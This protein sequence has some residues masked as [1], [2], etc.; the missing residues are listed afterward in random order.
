MGELVGRAVAVR[1]RAAAV[2][3]HAL[4]PDRVL[5]PMSM[6]MLV[7]VLV[8]L[9]LLLTAWTTPGTLADVVVNTV[10]A[11][12]FPGMG[13]LLVARRPSHPIGWLYCAA[14]LLAV[15]GESGMR[16]ATYTLVTA[17]DAALPG[18]PAAAWLG[19]E[20]EKVGLGLLPFLLLLFPDG[21]LP[22]R[23]WRPLAWLICL[24][25][26]L[27]V[28]AAAVVSGPLRDADGGA[29]PAVNPLAIEPVGTVVEPLVGLGGGLIF[30]AG[31]AAAGSLLLRFRTQRGDERQ[32][33]KWV[34]YAAV[35]MLGLIG[36]NTLLGYNRVALV[37]TA[38]PALALLSYALWGLTFAVL[39]LAMGVA[40]LK[41]RL[42]DIDRLISRTATYGVLWL[43]IAF[44]Y[45]GLAAALGVAAGEYLPLQVAVSCTIVATLGFQPARRRLEQLADRWVFGE[46]FGGHELVAQLGTALEH[47]L[48]ADE[49][50]PCVA[51]TVR[52]GLR[53]RWA[54]V[55][56]KS[57][58]STGISFEPVGAAGIGLHDTVIPH[59][60][61][62]LT[63][64]DEQIGIIECGPKLDGEFQASDHLLLATLGHQA[65]LAVRNAALATELAERLAEIEQQAHELAAS[66]TRIVQAEESGRRRIERDIH[67]G[68][69]QELVALLAKL[70]LARNQ[71]ARDPPLAETTLA[72]LQEDTRQALE[73]LRELARGIHP[74]VLSDRGLL[75][76]IEARVARLPIEVSID[77]D[78]VARGSRFP[79]EI[80]G[81]AYFLVCEGLANTLKHAA[82]QH[83]T[84]RLAATPFSV[85]LEVADDGRGFD[86]PVVAC[87]GLRGLT[88]RI[89]ALGGTLQ[90]V[91]QPGA[92]TSLSA[93][94]PL[95]TVRDG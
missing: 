67:D 39:P 80:E 29:L 65:A 36:A 78:G 7:L 54:R 60:A 73:D 88:D 3:T 63:Y 23:G 27:W 72:E 10:P 32:Q 16:F 5:W 45:A 69:Q 12:L 30:A 48:G 71:L 79:E 90:L 95:G 68:V 28:V 35:V 64:A 49:V 34:G 2:L 81:A 38:D 21:R 91:S 20:L 18:G 51:T 42:W 62:P 87:S 4:R 94:L 56:V 89:E 57:S 77:S 66:R 33:L 85:Q 70:R 59:V 47:A 43:A 6:L 1:T 26:G 13:V 74:P 84:V 25:D 8:A 75:E 9:D 53:T 24:G 86:P 22:S 61:V 31:L 14:F 92:G 19:G 46:R 44:V 11:L 50:A 41:Y 37:A 93:A 17:P 83:V 76:A 55:C 40:I 58:K 82:A 52:L 15:L